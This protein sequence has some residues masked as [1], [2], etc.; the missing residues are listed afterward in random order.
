MKP[1]LLVLA[2]GMGSRYGGLKQIDPVG[3]DG[4][5]ILDYSLFDAKKAGFGKVVF[6][7]RK[8]IEDD[9]KSVFAERLSTILPVEWVFQEI[10]ILPEGYNVPAD[11]VKPWG[12]GHAVLMASKAIN[13]PFA[14]INADDFY[15]REAFTK[16]NEFFQSNKNETDYA[17]IAYELKNTLSDFGSVSRGI[18]EVDE[19][20]WL[21]SVVENTKLAREGSEVYNTEADGTKS[22]V[23]EYNPVSM[24][25]WCF[26]PA[27]FNQVE[28]QFR[29]FI[30]DNISN[31]KS[32]FYIPKAIDE[33]IK[34]QQAR[35][36]VIPNSG[37]W[38]GITYQE[39]KPMVMDRIK[40]LT[41]R[42]VYP[43]SFYNG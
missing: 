27:F 20:G 41:D 33:L 24:N 32:E 1:T 16:A 19:D 42:E 11:R 28:T 15:G 21:L 23:S 37:E 40:A 22:L 26:K 4:Q 12:T 29:E 36:K 17:M 30:K 39:D 8:Q 9:F 35:V 3:P 18:C 6:I 25:F 7:I 14:V 43:V 34:S 10:D 31:P 13:E 2:A 5:T 38:F